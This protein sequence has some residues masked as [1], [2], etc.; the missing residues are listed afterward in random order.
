MD[1]RESTLATEVKVT[2]NIPPLT[3]QDQNEEWL[4]D[5][6]ELPKKEKRR[7][8]KR[9]EGRDTCRD[10]DV[11]NKDTDDS[12]ED[13]ERDPWRVRKHPS[14]WTKARYADDSAQNER[15]KGGSCHTRSF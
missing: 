12:E 9:A 3:N 11:N 6:K 10:F 7:Q 4:L 2:V 1:T 5:G 14:R 13:D 15:R 8:R